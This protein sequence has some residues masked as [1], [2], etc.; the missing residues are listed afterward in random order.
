[1]LKLSGDLRVSM[2]FVLLS[3]FASIGFAQTAPAARPAKPASQRTATKPAAKPAAAPAAPAGAPAQIDADT[4]GGY[5]ARPIGPAQTGGR[6]ADLE[7]VH[8]GQKLTIYVGSAAGGVFRSKDGGV[9]FRPVFDKQPVLSIGAIKIDP[10]DPKTIWVGTGESWTRNSVSVGAGVYRSKDG[11]DSWEFLG[12][13][14]SERIARIAINPKDSSMVYV[15]A[16]GHLWNANE[17]RGLYKTTDAGKHWTKVLSV[18]E[19]TGCAD[20]SMDPSNPDVL[21]AGMWQFRRHPYSFES[22][23]PKSGFF[24]STDG[25]KTWNKLTA[26]LPAGGEQDPIGRIAVAVAPTQPNR[27]YALVEAKHS[28]LYRSDDAGA[29]WKEM[30]SA[31]NL[32]GRP[33]Y[34]ARLVVDPTNPDRIY[35][36]G[37][38][39][40]VSDDGGK[41]F[42]GTGLGEG[43]GAHGDYHAVW[44]DPTNNEHLLVAT[45]GGV[46]QSPDRGGNFRHLSSMP[47]AQL[48][49]VGFDMDRP[50]NVYGGLQDNGTWMG[51]SNYPGGIYNRHWR[52]LGFGD[53]FWAMVDP[54]DPDIVYVEYQGGHA[55]RVRRSTGE[56]KDIRPL[57]RPAMQGKKEEPELRFNWNT[58]MHVGPKSGNLYLGSQFLMR[59]TNKGDTWD[60]ISPDL[61]TNNPEWLKQEQSGGV[62]VDNSDA[63]KYETIYHLRIAARRSRHLG[64]HRR[65]QR[66]G[67]AQRRGQ[68]DERHEERPWPAAEHLGLDHQ[69]RPLRSRHG[70]RHVRRTHV[71]RHEDLRLQDSRF[72]QDV[73][74]A[75]HS[76][77]HRL[78]TRCPRRPGG[79]QPAV[80]RH[81]ERI[82]PL[83]RRRQSLGAVH[84]Q[85]AKRSCARRA[86]ASA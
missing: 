3:A 61:T 82:V 63:E 14:D 70:L 71:R 46:Y 1:M 74:V 78:R 19:N 83:H 54:K 10:N 62:T 17:E 18:D 85:P 7:A 72:R 55:S 20:V 24:K 50:Y 4:F 8:E 49:H 9:T 16:T 48:Y 34:F 45:D 27:V 43:G 26:G 28:A 41:T 22:G 64:G 53:G 33:F 39:F 73:A 86:G 44:I 79:P 65:R 77:H 25:G 40:T 66:A 47:I 15:C 67:H 52:N 69:R 38:G 31:F 30:S 60:R 36:P 2:L 81:R 13:K 42:S 21:Y 35:K 59:S 57:P 32:T 11:G 68:L 84:R 23:G 80:C 51:P 75:R 76:R 12:L 6:V 5:E 56:M 58:G 37:F 29:T